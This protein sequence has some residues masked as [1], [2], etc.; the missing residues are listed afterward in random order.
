[1]KELV[2]QLMAE[3]LTEAQA[4]KAI[5]VIKNFA[6]AKFPLF[7]GAIDKLFDKYGPKNADDDFLD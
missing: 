6:K 4:Y 3:G 2:D 1:M 7:G 5:D